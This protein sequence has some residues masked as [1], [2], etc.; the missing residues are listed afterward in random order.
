MTHSMTFTPLRT[1]LISALGLSLLC[2]AACGGDNNT[3]S[4][5]DPGPTVCMTSADCDQEGGEYCTQDPSSGDMVCAEPVTCGEIVDETE[6]D[7][8]CADA[9]AGQSCLD[10]EGV[11]GS[12]IPECTSDEAC[13]EGER[14][15]NNEC[16]EGARSCDRDEDCDPGFICDGSANECDRIRACEDTSE[17]DT[18]N[19][20]YCIEVR[21][22]FACSIP[23]FCDQIL[24][25]NEADQYCNDLN[26]GD[27]CLDSGM[28]GAP[29]PACV[30]AADPDAFCQTELEDPDAV[31]DPAVGCEVD[32]PGG[33]FFYVLIDD[34]TM[35]C[36]T[37][38]GT[39]PGSDI[40]YAELI[41]D[42]GT[43]LGWGNNVRYIS[44]A[45][46]NGNDYIDASII[47]GTAPVP[48]IDDGSEDDGCPAGGDRFSPSTVVSLGCG[49]AMIVEFLNAGLGNIELMSMQNVLIGE[50]APV[51][52]QTSGGSVTGT[53]SYVVYLCPRTTAGEIP[54]VT[55]CRD[56]GGLISPSS[57]GGIKLNPITDMATQ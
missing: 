38:P 19:G 39:D 29:T 1:I 51:C 45:E 32:A 55:E 42:E 47:D 30:D 28:C 16:V 22:V 15:E 27:V 12:A 7:M 3:S 2:A 49:G 46:P 25:P 11:C 14:C 41:D 36:M 21:S 9:F 54:S 50:Y 13:M 48:L 31:C 40:M 33:S 44:G 6:A 8:Y 43:T 23:E 5:D 34:T 24:E 18:A 4:D 52:N 37:G 57:D 53:D 17:C 26:A 20:E 10:N 35:D 56:D